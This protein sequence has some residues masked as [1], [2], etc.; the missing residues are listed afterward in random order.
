MPKPL[1]TYL[2]ALLYFTKV[3]TCSSIVPQDG[4]LY[5]LAESRDR[6]HKE[7]A[8]RCRRLKGLVKRLKQQ[9]RAPRLNLRPQTQPLFCFRLNRKKLREGRYSLRTNLG[10]HNP[11]EL[12]QFY[13]QLTEVE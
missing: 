5:V 11:A 3:S 8:M 7:R 2:M 13:L 12:G 6:L 10:G 4:E 9:H 1:W